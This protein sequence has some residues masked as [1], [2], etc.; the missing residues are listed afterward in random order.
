MYR[1]CVMCMHQWQKQLL[2]LPL[3]PLHVHGL[4]RPWHLLL[5]RLLMLYSLLLTILECNLFCTDAL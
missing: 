1:L 2:G 3:F 5:C 4:C